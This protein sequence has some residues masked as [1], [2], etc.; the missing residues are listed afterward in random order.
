MTHSLSRISVLAVAR[1]TTACCCTH[2]FRLGRVR[3]GALGSR[4]VLVSWDLNKSELNERYADQALRPSVV[5]RQGVLCAA[6]WCF[7]RRFSGPFGMKRRVKASVTCDT[8]IGVQKDVSW[9]QALTKVW[10]AGPW[11]LAM[12]VR[13]SGVSLQWRRHTVCFHGSASRCHMSDKSR[14]YRADPYAQDHC[15]GSVCSCCSW[16]T[17]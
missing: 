3:G 17:V 9:A 16:S 2:D 6:V 5:P 14:L 13:F 12:V 1:H 8:H 11:Y 4:I 7:L 15:S 10:L